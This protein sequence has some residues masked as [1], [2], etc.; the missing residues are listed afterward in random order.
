MSLTDGAGSC[1]KI[2]HMQNPFL[3]HFSFH[4]LKKRLLG[5]SYKAFDEASR[6]FLSLKKNIVD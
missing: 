2:L 3:S 4:E 1:T 5:S 6:E